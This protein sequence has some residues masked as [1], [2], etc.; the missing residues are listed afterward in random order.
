[1][2][3]LF[4]VVS[5]GFGGAER[6]YLRLADHIVRQGF[7]HDFLLVVFSRETDVSSMLKDF[8]SPEL[9]KRM[10]VVNDFLSL[11]RLREEY[12]PSAIHLVTVNSR[13]LPLYKSLLKNT[14]SIL[15]LNS[16]LI[17]SGRY[18]HLIQRIAFYYLLKK[19]MI[20]DCL[21][22]NLVDSL[23]VTVGRLGYSVNFTVQPLP[24]TDLQ[25]FYPST[26]KERTIV[27]AAR[28]RKFK[29]PEIAVKAAYICRDQMRKKGYRLLVC[30]NGTLKARLLRLVNRKN[31]TDIVSVMG[32][33]DM[34]KILPFSRVFL[35][36]Q[37]IENY[38]SQALIEAISS[39][40]F[41]I[42]SD[43]GNTSLLVKPQFGLL[44]RLTAE[45][46]ADALL[47]VISKND[48]EFRVISECARDFAT[49]NFLIDNST[50]HLLDLWNRVLL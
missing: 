7:S 20:V 10:F 45:S 48:N 44:I 42:A 35:S 19:S 5:R 36:L 41:I 13:L 17:A 47:D 1:V 40:N 32:S 2:I 50:R 30:G 21:Y 18:E 8:I 16:Y 37:D 38:P 15:S 27:F 6:R 28:L 39:G 34:S 23:R 46:L 11:R 12:F 14:R 4:L 25:R 31:I 3:W 22:P 43:T 49:N 29:N 26:N 24:F 9:A 33:T